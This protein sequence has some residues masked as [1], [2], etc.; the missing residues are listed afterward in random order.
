MPVGWAITIVVLCVA[1][2]TLAVVVLGLLR[3][4]TPVLE[5]AA[6]QGGGP[7]P[8]QQGPPVGSPLPHFTVHSADGE[9]TE[10]QLR[11]RST[12]M[13]FMSSG[14]G[15]CKQLAQDIASA[16][17]GA[18]AEQILVITDPDGP[19][20]LGIPP[21]LRVLIEPGGEV[22]DPLSVIGTPFTVAVDSAGIV[23]A[24]QVTNTVE[25]LSN[26]AALMGQHSPSSA[27]A[28]AAL[29]P[30]SGGVANGHPRPVGHQR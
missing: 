29:S 8:L 23:R 6:G 3:Q 16:D 27:P 13:V 28:G 5:R 24:G 12:L 2:V 11:G 25:Q 7:G 20:E 19:R 22:S 1:V 17:L 14:C 26:L 18:L 30:G 9:T 21:D 10:Q 4:V 15:P